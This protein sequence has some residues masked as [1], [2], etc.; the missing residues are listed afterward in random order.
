MTSAKL[1]DLFKMVFDI[2]ARK[3]NVNTWID[4]ERIRQSDKTISNKVGEFHQKL[5]GGV[6]GWID[7][8]VGHPL[9]VDLKN[10]KDTKT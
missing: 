2:N 7:L 9:G 6:K 1:I 4:M 5:L 8:G 3:I 10:K